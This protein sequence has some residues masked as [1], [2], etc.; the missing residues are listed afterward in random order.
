MLDC[1][2]LIFGEAEF[3]LLVL[4]GDPPLTLEV[5]VE[6]E[7]GPAEPVLILRGVGVLDLGPRVGLLGGGE[8]PLAGEA[9]RRV[10]GVLE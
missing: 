2:A 8:S 3:P 9:F 6:V 10:G 5:E 1:H 4:I 7:V